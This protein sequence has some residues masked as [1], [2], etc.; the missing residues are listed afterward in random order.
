MLF[1]TMDNL[2][3]SN[4]LKLLRSIVIS[5]LPLDAMLRVIIFAMKNI[6]QDTFA[7]SVSIFTRCYSLSLYHSVRVWT[8]KVVFN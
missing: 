6:P 1:L 8:L 7:S 3:T 5:N 2:I 4:R